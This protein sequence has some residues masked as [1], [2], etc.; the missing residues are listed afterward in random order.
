MHSIIDE[1]LLLAGVRRQP[2]TA[3]PLD[4]PN[5]VQEALSRIADLAR[6][7]QAQINAPAGFP[8]AVGHAPWV[9]EIWVNYLSNAIKYGG[10]PPVIQLGGEPAPTGG[11]MRFWVRDNGPG[12]T[13]GQVAR[14]FQTFSRVGATSVEGHGLGLSIV[15]RI[16]EK[17]GGSAGVASE[18][19]QGSCFWF[20]LPAGQPPGSPVTT[21]K[22]E[23]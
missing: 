2:V 4:M 8:Q 9:V 3:A 19:G 7:R 13:P 21:G 10:S 20:E 16:A 5:I 6:P 1:L 11:G 15:R 12:L 22:L 14:L 23:S 18:L 17:L